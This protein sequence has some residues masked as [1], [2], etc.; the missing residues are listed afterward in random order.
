MLRSPTPSA[1]QFKL[2]VVAG[3]RPEC[4]KLASLVRALRARPEVALTLINSGQHLEMVERTFAH[5]EIAT[6]QRLAPPLPPLSLS[7]AVRHLR[8]HLVAEIALERPDAIIVQG[9]TSTAYAGALAG[10][11]AGLPVVHVE[12]GLRT[13]DPMRPFPE[14]MFRRR[15]ATVAD[16]HFAPTAGAAANL[17]R[18]GHAAERVFNVGNTIVDLLRETSAAIANTQLDGGGSSRDAFEQ[19]ETPAARA[20]RVPWRERFRRLVTLTLHRRENYGRGLITVCAAM[21]ELLETHEDLGVVCPVH[22]NPVVGHRVRRML[23]GHPRVCLT[24]PLDYRPFVRLLAESTL[25]VTDSG[26]IQE[27]APYLGVPVL[28]VRDSTER[29]EALALGSTRLVA[30]EHHHIVHEVEAALARE[31]PAAI[32]FDAQAPFGD[33]RSGERIVE[34][35]LHELARRSTATASAGATA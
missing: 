4:L 30:V 31:R 7:R 33:G 10:R 35:L 8:D 34:I 1:P 32:A 19:G 15:I 9:D 26:G 20:A 14:E 18:E 29:P 11:A 6:D 3:T 13:G 17:L 16:Y 21:L 5:V 2:A 23:G 25:V 22:P 27:E 12:A 24:E 28:V